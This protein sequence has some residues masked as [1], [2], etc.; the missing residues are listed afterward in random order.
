MGRGREVP[1]PLCDGR[2]KVLVHRSVKIRM[3]AEGMDHKP[4][5]PFDHLYFEW[6]D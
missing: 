4:K 6:V 2:E 3:E 5:A 1:Q